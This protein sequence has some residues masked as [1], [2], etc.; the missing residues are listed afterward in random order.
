[1]YY[2]IF[3]ANKNTAIDRQTFCMSSK[4]ILTQCQLNYR[5]YVKFKPYISYIFPILAMFSAKETQ[6]QHRYNSLNIRH[7]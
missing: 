7:L 5:I 1:M 4:R 2:L 6:K 3:H